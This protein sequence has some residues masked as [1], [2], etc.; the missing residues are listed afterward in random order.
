MSKFWRPL[1][2]LLINCEVELDLS[3]SKEC[4]ISEMSVPPRIS[5][6]TNARPP[7]W[8]RKAIKTTGPTM[9][10]NNAKFYIPVVT[11]PVADNKKFSEKIKQEFKR[12]IS[13]NNINLG[14]L[15]DLK[16]IAFID[17]LY[18]HSKMATM[19]LLENLLISFIYH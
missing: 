2:L 14:H 4:I 17:C 16:F 5:C 11:L 6:N 18:F 10:I 3:L 8:H 1:D 9:Q 7:V 15:I 19:I 13:W 12:T